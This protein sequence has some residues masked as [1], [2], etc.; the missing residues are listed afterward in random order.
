MDA[1]TRRL[2]YG[3]FAALAVAGLVLVLVAIFLAPTGVEYWIYGALGIVIVAL[4][5]EV[6]LLF[7]GRPKRPADE[8]YDFVIDAETR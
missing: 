7:V 1:G 5:G 2:L 6:V 3:V 8:T 4:V